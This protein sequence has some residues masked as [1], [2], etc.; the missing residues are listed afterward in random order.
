M[1]HAWTVNLVLLQIVILYTECN[2]T[3]LTTFYYYKLF[4]TDHV[5]KVRTDIFNSFFLSLI[6]IVVLFWTA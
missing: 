3:L 1:R 5:F 2:M 6:I 4:V